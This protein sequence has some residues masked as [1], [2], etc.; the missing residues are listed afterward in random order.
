[1]ADSPIAGTGASR[2]ELQP[3]QKLF[4]EMPDH[5]GMAFVLEANLASTR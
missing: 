2:G 1:M 4:R 3:P 5:S